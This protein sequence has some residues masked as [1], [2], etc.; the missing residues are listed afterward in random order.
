MHRLSVF[1]KAS[2]PLGDVMST[3]SGLAV[4]RVYGKNNRG[5]LRRH[6]SAGLS[7]GVVP[8][9]YAYFN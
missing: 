5:R 3:A 9:K 6:Q 4:F 7:G 2:G 8:S 1:V